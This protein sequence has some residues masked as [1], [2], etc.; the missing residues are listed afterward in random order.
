MSLRMA[1][2]IAGK[3]EE[4]EDSFKEF[5]EDI[6]MAFQI[7]DDS[8][9]LKREDVKFGKAYGNDVTEGKLSLPVV[10]AL[11]GLSNEKQNR[12]KKILARHT[13][14][15]KYIN[16]AV[17]LIEESGSIEKSVSKARQMIKDAWDKLEDKLNNNYDLKDLQEMTLF[18][19]E[20]T[21]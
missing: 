21:Y 1:C 6:G 5:G 20:R 15:M 10:Y 16:E 19:V 3:S 4:V 7:I 8:L 2:V 9:D 11:K 18:F 13:K 12:L 17:K 14:D